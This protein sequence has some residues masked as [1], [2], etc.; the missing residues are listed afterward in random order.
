MT[1]RKASALDPPVD[2]A[3]RLLDVLVAKIVET[4][5]TS[6]L[7]A[8]IALPVGQA[9]AQG[10]SLDTL[11][12]RVVEAISAKIIQDEELLKNVCAVIVNTLTS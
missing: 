8:K 11:T 5:D 9:V 12:D 4:L 3:N 6:A 10:I 7:A 2:G 1:K